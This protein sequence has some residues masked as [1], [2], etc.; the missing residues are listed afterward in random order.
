[1]R[2]RPSG[3]R[4]AQLEYAGIID[5]FEAVLSADAVRRLKPARE[6]YR[7]A[8]ERLGV[9]PGEVLLVAAHLADRLLA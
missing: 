3:W 6:P 5:R 8:A 1:V 7:M 4:R 9:E 2:A